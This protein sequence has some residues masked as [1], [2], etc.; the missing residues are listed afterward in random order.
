MVYLGIA[1]HYGNDRTKEDLTVEDGVIEVSALDWGHAKQEQ[2][3]VVANLDRGAQ[4][5]KEVECCTL[6]ELL[7]RVL[8]D[9]E[10][11]GLGTGKDNSGQVGNEHHQPGKD[12]NFSTKAKC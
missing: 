4:T 11:D 1:G 2:L 6:V 7:L 10:Y 8:E 5:L 9:S 3:G 12:F